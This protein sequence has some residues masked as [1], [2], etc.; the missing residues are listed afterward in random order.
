LSAGVAPRGFPGGVGHVYET[1]AEE[2]AMP[3]ENIAG[4]GRKR[5]QLDVPVERLH[6]DP[7]NPRL[8]AESQGASEP[9]LLNVLHANFNL[10]ELADSM[11]TNGYFDEEP[12]VA[13]PI[14]TPK[15]LA[16]AGANPA[17]RKFPDYLAFIQD[18]STHFTVVEGNRRLATALILLDSTLRARLNIRSWPI[19]S[20]VAADDL[21][22]L[23]VIIYPTR[24][25][26]VPYLGVR[27]IVGIQK[28]DIYARARYIAGMV[29]KK[30]RTLD[31]IQEQIGDRQNSARKSYVCYRAL[32]QVENEFDIDT[33]PAQSAFSFL[34]LALGQGSIKRFLGLPTR[35][36]DIP[37]DQP[38]TRKYLPNLKK[39]YLWLFGDRVKKPVIT[40]SRDITNFLSSVVEN[41]TA[42]AHLERTGRLEEA[43]DLSDGE[44]K[45]LLKYLANANTKLEAAL[46][47][48]HR[49][50]TQEVRLEADKCFKTAT[51]LRQTLGD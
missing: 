3:D 35:W 16:Q 39:L 23:P 27:H 11:A 41:A 51:Q 32:Q 12:L 5:P 49:H 36:S 2:M 47:V 45:M 43:Y 42:V 22:V 9:E 21:G 46:G 26:V 18:K 10:E 29:E 28:W 1:I 20:K 7:Q 24:D 17:S 4:S 38:V 19:P 33:R 40:E 34:L 50:K 25:A 48:A 6:P 15:G 14:G 37:A 30:E 31:Q 44:E 13:I 8:P